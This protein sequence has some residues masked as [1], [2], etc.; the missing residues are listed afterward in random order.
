MKSSGAATPQNSE[1]VTGSATA[2]CSPTDE[3]CP[4]STSSALRR[5]LT[6]SGLGWFGLVGMYCSGHR[7]DRNRPEY[8]ARTSRGC[9]RRSIS[10]LVDSHACE[11]TL[12]R[13]DDTR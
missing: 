10:A 5:D 12:K 13:V 6:V 7:G 8:L 9:S 2:V 11:Q 3:T 1:K 4:R